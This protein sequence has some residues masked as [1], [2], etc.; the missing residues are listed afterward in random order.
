MKKVVFISF[1]TLLFVSC[2]T[3]NSYVNYNDAKNGNE[4]S[5]AK[6]VSVNDFFKHRMESEIKSIPGKDWMILNE[7]NGF[8]YF[9]KFKVQ[10]KSIDYQT[11]EPFYKVN[12]AHLEKKFP[13]YEN[14][15]GK[16][17][18][19]KF[20]HQFIKPLLKEEVYP[21]CGESY[22]IDYSKKD[23]KLTDKGIETDVEFTAKCYKKKL[24]DAKIQ[25]TLSAKS[26]AVLNENINIKSKK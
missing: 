10:N 9:G 13:S 16:H 5:R 19:G 22:T 15:T 14:T 1:L 20:F 6:E 24:F 25:A 8:V 23:Y 18:K 21:V 7:Q 3:G 12:K 2:G 4:L 11:I 26:L 17:V